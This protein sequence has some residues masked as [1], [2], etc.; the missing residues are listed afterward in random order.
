MTWAKIPGAM[1]YACAV[2]LGAACDSW[3]AIG[4]VTLAWYYCAF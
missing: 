3:G 2:W 1:I 4:C